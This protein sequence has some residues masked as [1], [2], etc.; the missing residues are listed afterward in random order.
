MGVTV[1]VTVS[2]TVWRLM[3]ATLHLITSNQWQGESETSKFIVW[4]KE[5]RKK[6][7]GKTRR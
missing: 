2:V 5:R 3:E 7:K 6:I 1:I 4:T